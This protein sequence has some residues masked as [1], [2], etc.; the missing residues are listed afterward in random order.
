LDLDFLVFAPNNSLATKILKIKWIR[1]A[2]LECNW[3]PI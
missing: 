3:I 1:G 2:K